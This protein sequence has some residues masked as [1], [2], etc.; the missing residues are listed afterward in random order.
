MLVEAAASNLIQL[1]RRASNG[2]SGLLGCSTL[3]IEMKETQIFVGTVTSNICGTYNFRQNK[4]LK[5]VDH[6]Y[7]GIMKNKIKKLKDI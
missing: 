3:Q 1:L 5:S 4:A 2:R 6:C 7:I